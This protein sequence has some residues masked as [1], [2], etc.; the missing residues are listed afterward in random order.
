[1]D[2]E[3]LPDDLKIEI[4]INLTYLELFKYF[5]VLKG[6]YDSSEFW[7]RKAAYDTRKDYSDPL[8]IK[9]F[10]LP[11][12]DKDL[13][14]ISVS[15]RVRYLITLLY[16]EKIDLKITHLMS[17]EYLAKISILTNNLK[18]LESLNIPTNTWNLVDLAIFQR[19]YE[20][21]KILIVKNRRYSP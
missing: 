2:L 16:S 9:I 14:F 11:R 3:S 7:R 15:P 18:Y 8:L 5:T 12:Y 17:K 20:I 19:K 4:L 1:M 6:Y 21:V 13:N 10:E